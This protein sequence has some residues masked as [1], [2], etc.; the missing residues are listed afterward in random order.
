MHGLA[1]G[2]SA[3][4]YFEGMH[5]PAPRGGEAQQG[6]RLPR[7]AHIQVQVCHPT[8]SPHSQHSMHPIVNCRGD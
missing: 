3:L 1:A 4:T 2:A 5:H 7:P 6:V 8:A